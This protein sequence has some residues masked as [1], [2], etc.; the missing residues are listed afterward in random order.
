MKKFLIRLKSFVSGF[1][2][3]VY[4]PPIFAFTCIALLALT[5]FVYYGRMP[6]GY[7]WESVELRMAF[8]QLENFLICLSLFALL[9]LFIASFVKL[10]KDRVGAAFAGCGVFLFLLPA[11]L[12]M[13]VMI[14]GAAMFA[15]DDFFYQSITKNGIYEDPLGVEIFTPEEPPVSIYKSTYIEGDEEFQTKIIKANADPVRPLEELKREIPS[16]TKLENENL[17]LLCEY[18][19]SNCEWRFMADSIY[20]KSYLTIN[21][22]FKCGGI[23]IREKYM[24]NY[25]TADETKTPYFSYDLCLYYMSPDDSWKKWNT[26]TLE[27]SK[28]GDREVNALDTGFD[29]GKFSVNIRDF[30][31]S[32]P[33]MTFKTLELLEEEFARVRK[34]KAREEIEGILPTYSVKSGEASLKL[35]ATNNGGIYNSEIWVNAGEPG[36]IYLRAYEANSN[37]RLSESRLHKATNEYVGYSKDPSKVFFAGT[38]FTIHEGD[39]GQKYVARFEVWFQPSGKGPERKLL[40]KH[41]RIEGW[42]R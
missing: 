6:F 12:F 18:F 29:I 34:L 27:K 22:R 8:I 20:G 17:E 41:Y 33:N 42:M 38:E 1:F 13:C 39:W 5:S 10:A 14:G 36:L 35:Y 2:S 25:S 23:P 19:A 30:S 32:A 15:D 4:A 9:L 21:R 37:R 40:E 16:L 7:R 26:T 28:N 31:M 11:F 24:G 3:S